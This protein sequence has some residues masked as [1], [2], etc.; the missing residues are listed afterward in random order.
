MYLIRNI[1]NKMAE[2]NKVIDF[3]TG[4]FK[5]QAQKMNKIEPIINKF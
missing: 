3:D 4:Y 5:E 2:A 1:I